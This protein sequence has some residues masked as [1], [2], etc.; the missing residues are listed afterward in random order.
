MRLCKV[1]VNLVLACLWYSW[2]RQLINLKKT[3]AYSSCQKNKTSVTTANPQASIQV[4]ND[5][6]YCAHSAITWF[7]PE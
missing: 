2:E 1:G 5:N 3:S 6:D 4:R 7:Q